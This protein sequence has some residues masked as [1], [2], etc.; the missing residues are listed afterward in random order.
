MALV[1]RQ[2]ARLHL[3]PLT[4]GILYGLNEGL[5]WQ[6]V[7]SVLPRTAAAGVTS[8]LPRPEP[9]AHARP[10]PAGLS[11]DCPRCATSSCSTRRSSS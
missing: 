6:D 11:I 8:T 10:R 2:L 5:G 4:E 1:E 9:G 7:R 3:P